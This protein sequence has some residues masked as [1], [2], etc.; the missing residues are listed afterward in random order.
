MRSLL[1]LALIAAFCG[2]ANANDPDSRQLIECA[3]GKKFKKMA[4][5]IGGLKSDKIDTIN[6]NPSFTL[7]P[8][9]GGDLPKRVFVRL[10]NG[11]EKNLTYSADGEV[12]NFIADFEGSSGA[13]FCVED[14]SRA[15]QPKDKDAYALNM[16]FNMNFINNSGEYKMAELKDG[17]KDGKTALKK[18]IGG[19]GSLFVPNLTH[20]YVEFED[21]DAKPLFVARKDGKNIGELSFD[22][23]GDAYLIAYNALSQKR[24][25][26]FVV[27]GGAHTLSPS[28]SPEKMAKIMGPK[29]KDDAE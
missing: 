7:L 6:T 18:I 22:R 16:N 21:K 28:M 24:A 12:T 8:N 9:D 10:R 4:D 27:S 1:T 11:D 29:G 19:P 13:E 26:V 23:L 15:G 14:P 5:A 3:P 25:D 20:L 17:L 2:V